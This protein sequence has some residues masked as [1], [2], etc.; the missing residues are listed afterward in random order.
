[1]A[2]IEDALERLRTDPAFRAQ[3]ATDLRSALAGYE[4]SADDLSRLAKAVSANNHGKCVVEQR[5][6]KA[7]FFGLF[8]Q[9]TEGTGV[10]IRGPSS[11]EEATD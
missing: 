2:G 6:S 4:L 7:G 11:P 10:I 8:A 3:L 5:T 1:M 9:I